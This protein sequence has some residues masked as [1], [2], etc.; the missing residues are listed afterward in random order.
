MKV[1]KQKDG[2]DGYSIEY[3]VEKVVFRSSAEADFDMNSKKPRSSL[4]V[5]PLKEGE[6]AGPQPMTRRE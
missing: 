3:E 6:L 5:R 1:T 4:A 2:P